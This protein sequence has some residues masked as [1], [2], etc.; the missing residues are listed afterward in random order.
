[1]TRF[2][3]VQRNEPGELQHL[4]EVFA[5][6]GLNIVAQHYQTDGKIG[7]VVLDVEG[8]VA[9]GVA[10]LE[11]IRALPGTIRARLLNRV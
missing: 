11:E 9:N 5:G 1:V 6:H 2:I 8:S 4:N 7:Y 3:Q 10:I